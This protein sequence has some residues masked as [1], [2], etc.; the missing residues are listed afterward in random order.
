MCSWQTGRS[1][2]IPGG[3]NALERLRAPSTDVS[4]LDHAVPSLPRPFDRIKRAGCGMN[5]QLV[6]LGFPCLPELSVSILMGE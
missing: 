6:P 5:L 3:R 1:T 2:V 4:S